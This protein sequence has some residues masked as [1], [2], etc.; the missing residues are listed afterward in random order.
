MERLNGETG[1]ARI[2]E[3][4]RDMVG[5][6]GETLDGRHFEIKGIEEVDGKE[7]VAIKYHL[8]PLTRSDRHPVIYLLPKTVLRR[9]SSGKWTLSPPGEIINLS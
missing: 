3:E 5:R 9:I 6:K 1:Y 2:L 8:I 4:V 7:R